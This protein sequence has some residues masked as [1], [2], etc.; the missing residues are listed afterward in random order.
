MTYAVLLDL[1]IKYGPTAVALGEKLAKAI[2]DGKANTQVS[3]DDWAELNRL[4]NQ[5]AAD[6]YA[7]AGITPP[8]AS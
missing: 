3:A 4:A 5:S 2:I 7:R 8:P 1:L 6:I